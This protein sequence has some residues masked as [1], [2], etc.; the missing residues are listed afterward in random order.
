M[1]EKTTKKLDK[2]N[3]YPYLT[4]D[5]L[6]HL[7]VVD[8]AEKGKAVLFQSLSS[9]SYAYSYVGQRIEGNVEP[10]IY[11]VGF[12]AKSLLDSPLPVV[13]VYIRV[14][15][16]PRVWL[17]FKRAD[18]DPSKK[19]NASMA[20]FQRR[21]TN[22]WKYYTIDFDLSKTVN[23]AGNFMRLNEQGKINIENSAK[24]DLADFHISFSSTTGNSQYLFTDV[25]F[26]K[27]E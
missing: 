25:T 26:T 14:N 16:S 18:L 5:V 24:S 1:N 6:A 20:L 23:N 11:R 15:T 27:V 13:N 21:I 7:S 17:F 9:P 19:P 22:E 8:D 4:S 2:G 10:G 3:W 12:W